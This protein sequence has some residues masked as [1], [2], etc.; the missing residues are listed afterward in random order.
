M[1]AGRLIYSNPAG[2]GLTDEGR[3]LARAYVRNGRL[4]ELF[5]R[6][7][8]R[9]PPDDETASRLGYAL[10]APMA[11]A[12][13]VMLRHPKQCRHGHPIPPGDCCG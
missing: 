12:I 8:L 2:V 11:D 4:M 9:V 5:L 1:T 13:C 6:D 10:T 3:Y 7:V